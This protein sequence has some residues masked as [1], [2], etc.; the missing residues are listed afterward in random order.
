M[1]PLLFQQIYKNLET[2][3]QKKR[4]NIYFLLEKNNLQGLMYTIST[5][6]ANLDLEKVSRNDLSTELL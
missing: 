1:E 2:A 6:F 5:V 3:E 4:W